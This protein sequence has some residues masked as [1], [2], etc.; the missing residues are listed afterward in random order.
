M[1]EPKSLKQ[2]Y[3]MSR[4]QE[5]TNLYKKFHKQQIRHLTLS[6]SNNQAPTQQQPSYK[7]N[8][9]HESTSQ[10]STLPGLLPTPQTHIGTQPMRRPTRTFKSTEM[11]ERR[12]KGLC[13]WCDEKVTSGTNA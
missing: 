3:N 4:L 8:K 10:L 5:N 1:F 2:A 7:S 13:F 6:F 9:F 11:E 12:A